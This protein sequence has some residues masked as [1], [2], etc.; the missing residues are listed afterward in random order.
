M[1]PETLSLLRLLSLSGLIGGT[2][3]YAEL[4]RR[5]VVRRGTAAER[6]EFE[7]HGL[8]GLVRIL[9][10]ADPDASDSQLDLPAGW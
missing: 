5:R 8:H 1:E 9:L 3:E 4:V 7:E 10:V 2:I 6:A